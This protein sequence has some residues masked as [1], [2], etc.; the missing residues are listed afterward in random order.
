LWAILSF[1]AVGLDRTTAPIELRERLAF[2]DAEIP[3]LRPLTD[4]AD[5]LLDQ[6]AILSTCNR[7]ELYGAAPSRP[8]ARRLGALLVAS[9]S[10]GAA[11]TASPRSMRSG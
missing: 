1:V 8:A 11:W 9:P 10:P 7:I 5:A 4:P 3:A 6:A 2:A